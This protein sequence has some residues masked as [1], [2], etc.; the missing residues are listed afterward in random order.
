[1]SDQPGDRGAPFDRTVVRDRSIDS[2]PKD[3]I[4]VR[5]SHDRDLTWLQAYRQQSEPQNTRFTNCSEDELDDKLDR[6]TA[7]LE[8]RE[9][10]NV[11]RE[12]HA[13]D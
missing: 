4:Q 11:E 10:S 13:S 3:P 8:A 2:I 9:S 12:F 7:A 5:V 6:V 1:M